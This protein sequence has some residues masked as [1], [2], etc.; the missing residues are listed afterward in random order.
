MAALLYLRDYAGFLEDG[1]APYVRC[2]VEF[3][4]A[5]NW[6]ELPDLAIRF[7]EAS[8]QETRNR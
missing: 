4:Q 3:S 6:L 2:L 1:V 8:Q 7:R 5:E